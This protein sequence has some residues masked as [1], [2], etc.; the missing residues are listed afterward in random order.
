MAR[1]T[2]RATRSGSP[3]NGGG[4]R[5]GGHA[6]AH[7]AGLDA[8]GP[9]PVPVV[10]VVEAFQVGGQPRLGGTVE[11]DGRAGSVAGDGGEDT[12]RSRRPPASRRRRA[13]SQKPTVLAKSTVASARARSGSA[14][15]TVCSGEVG[16]RHD[17]GVDPAQ[18]L[19]RRVEGG[20]E[21]LGA[22][23]GRTETPGG[24]S[25]RARP[26]PADR[27]RTGRAAPGLARG[28]RV[29]RRALRGAAPTPAPCRASPR[30]G[31]RSRSIPRHAGSP[32]MRTD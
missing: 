9:Q 1:T 5:A 3:P 20:G 19:R 2:R 15:R 22:G 14:S 11:D 13:C 16:R 25:R 8:D 24:G 30:A 10:A 17:D 12:Q 28:G 31:R 18:A 23:R 27:A 29:R 6:G 32:R 4:S 26:A 7:E 21:R